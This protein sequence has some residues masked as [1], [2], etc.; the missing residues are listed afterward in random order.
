MI[1]EEN[2]N[3]AS[4]TT[5]GI[6]AKA[7]WYAEYNSEAELL[8]LS[9]TEQFLNNQVLNIGE[10]SNLLFI[11]DFNGLVL[12]S[13]IT[14]ITKY[15]NSK[16][17]VFV[18][19]GAGVNWQYLID[20]CLE[21]NLA[22]LENLAGIP[23]TVG[24]SAVQNVGAYGVEAGN[25]IFAVECFDTLTR[26]TRRF[27]KAECKFGYRDS[28]FKKEGK[29][30]YIVLRVSFLLKPGNKAEVL[31]YHPLDILAE[32]LG[33]QPTIKE[34]AQEVIN[35]R[36]SKLP[37]PKL[38][39]SAGSFFKNPV[40]GVYHYKELCKIHD[41]KIPANET[42][43]GRMK[44]S[45]AWLIDQAGMNGFHVGGAKV[46]ERQPLVIVNTGNATAKD[47]TDLAEAVRCAVR[48]KFQLNLKPEVN[49]IDSRIRVTILGSG[50][51]KGIPEP[52][53][54]CDVCR[55]TDRHDT[56]LRA[57]ALVRTHGL[58]ILIDPSPDF[59]YQ[60]I[61]NNIFDIDAVLITHS[62]YDHV[63]GLD[64]LRPYCTGDK[65]PIYVRDD[66]DAD[67]RRRLDYCFGENPY[68]GV[69]TFDMRII[70]NY[71][72]YIYGL[73]V[74]PV[75]VVH[76]IKPIFGYR[77]GA[78]AYVTDAKSISER[79]KEK[80]EN[81]DTLVV[82]ALRDREHF[83]HFSIAEALAL[84]DELEPK[85]AYLTHFCHEAGMHEEILARMPENVF[86]AY[87]G[88]QFEII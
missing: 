76:G 12:R 60:A 83:A 47:V 75:E 38:I 84:I 73:K 64:D 16:G 26:K 19:A 14:G 63:G 78:F 34:L 81:L 32:R 31:N 55:S 13:C 9:R 79:E 59:R 53:C 24:A 8:K 82:N 7:R 65:F 61:K 68:P 40:I 45:A 42:T 22:G 70:D 58:S 33:H 5:F 72:F 27:N 54:E 28:F 10:G 74:E 25:R 23:G 43:D 87:D 29:E 35:I 1:L 6:P 21:E 2:K 85:R 44:I 46:W 86:P 20:W 17:R 56:R 88:L 30:R 39:G 57:S 77:I 52:A 67:L 71:P 18:I 80:L 49:Y 3:L 66:V 41:I 51:S 37:N 50:T 11:N 15:E 48:R 69:P 4:L 62:H 36:N